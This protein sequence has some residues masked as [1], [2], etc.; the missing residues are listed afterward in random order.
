MRGG[1]VVDLE[2]VE[3][4]YP[5]I[6]FKSQTDRGI[7]ALLAKFSVSKAQIIDGSSVTAVWELL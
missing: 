3:D 5:T 7:Q 4:T 1:D 6:E 2:I